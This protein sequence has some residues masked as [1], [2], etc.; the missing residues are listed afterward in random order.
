MTRIKFSE[1]WDKLREP[2]FTTIRSY[3]P[4]KERYYRGLVGSAFVLWRETGHSFWNEHKVGVAT[5]RTVRIVR[6]ADLP[7]A[8]FRADVL[9]G[10]TPDRTWEARL[11]AMDRALLLELEN[12]TGI[13]AEAPP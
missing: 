2:R 7:A 12:H 10:G 8:E 3:R 5:L 4:D 6:P 1:D 9:R 11:L 13:L